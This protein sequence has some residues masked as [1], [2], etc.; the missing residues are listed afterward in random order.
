MEAINHKK[1]SL[2]VKIAISVLLIAL[3]NLFWFILIRNLD[4]NQILADSTLKVT[5]SLLIPI[6]IFSLFLSCCA[7]FSVFIKSRL[8]WF[9]VLLIATADY[10]LL[11]GGSYLDFLGEI[12]IVVALYI[13]LL[14]FH[15]YEVL[16]DGKPSMTSRIS[17]AFSTTSLVISIILAFNFYSIYAHTLSSSNLLV[18]NH[19]LSKMLTPIVR[20]YNDDLKI[21]SPNEKF[22]DYQLRLS[23]ETKLTPTQVRTNTLTK[24]NIN[25]ASDNDLMKDLLKSSLDNSILKLARDYGKTIH[26][27]ISLGLGIIVQTLI[28]V[29]STISNYL[30]LGIFII[31]RKLKIT[32]LKTLNYVVERDVWIN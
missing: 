13:F 5:L 1:E 32:K 27:L 30:T 6:V 16:V 3:G 10:F 7:I 20:I 15:K 14:N 21:V 28:T 19:L 24:L 26:I 31:L 25:K 18:S 11:T 22:I 12:A 9:L 4:T 8:I 17:S 23:K 29:S 2:L